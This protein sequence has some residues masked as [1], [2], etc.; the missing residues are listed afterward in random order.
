MTVYDAKPRGLYI[1]I[2]NKRCSLNK[3]ICL[4]QLDLQSQQTM[5]ATTSMALEDA[6]SDRL[7]KMEE[8]CDP[9]LSF[10]SDEACT[11]L[12]AAAQSPFQSKSS[13]TVQEARDCETSSMLPDLN[14]PLEEDYTSEIL[15]GMS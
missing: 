12:D 9:A 8:V 5:K 7:Q 13:L 2:I 11:N 14:L 15:Y 10:P 1:N 3:S 6:L 4:L